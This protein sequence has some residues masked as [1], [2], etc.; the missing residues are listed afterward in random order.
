MLPADIR[1]NGQFYHLTRRAEKALNGY[2]NY[3]RKQR[4]GQDLSDINNLR[5]EPMDYMVED[6]SEI[7]SEQKDDLAD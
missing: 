5:E 1:R 7:T 3:V 2:M 4:A 6:R